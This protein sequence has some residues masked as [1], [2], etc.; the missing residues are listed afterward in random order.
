MTADLKDCLSSRHLSSL[1]PR[2]FKDGKWKTR[3]IIPVALATVCAVLPLSI[4]QLATAILVSVT[5]ALYQEVQSG[6]V[7][8]RFKTD[9]FAKE[10]E[11]SMTPTKSHRHSVP[12]TPSAPLV[13][14]QHRHRHSAPT[15]R[16][17][18]FGYAAA[19]GASQDPPPQESRG[20]HSNAPI[21][22]RTARPAPGLEPPAERPKPPP[23]KVRRGF[24]NEVDTL[25]RCIS[26]AASSDRMVRELARQVQQTIRPNFPEA[27]VVGFSTGDLAHSTTLG[28][29][30]PEVDLV[31]TIN[32]DNLPGQLLG[33]LSRTGGASTAKLDGRKVQKSAIRACTNRLVS[34]CGFKFRRSAFRGP[35]PKVTLLAPAPLSKNRDD[36]PSIPVDLSVNTATPQCADAVLKACRRFGPEAQSL[37]VLVKRWAR[38]RGICHS[39]KGHLSP[40]SWSLLAAFFLQVAPAGDAPGM[41]PLN[42]VR[43]GNS[44]FTMKEASGN[45]SSLEFSKAGGVDYPSSDTIR[46]KSVATLFQEFVLFYYKDFNWRSE[47]VSLRVGKRAAP[48]LSLPL[49]IVVS[50]AGV[51]T[52]VG[53]H[54]E[55]PFELKTNL[56]MSM[57]EE[58]FGRMQEE[59][60]RALEILERATPEPSLAEL[61]EPWVLSNGAGQD[62]EENDFTNGS[63]RSS[64]MESRR[65]SAVSVSSRG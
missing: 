59:L 7:Q 47:A 37:V 56:G 22:E 14:E 55:D 20:R 60:G 3:S 65:D 5:Y 2:L 49:H 10:E 17:I 57:T 6:A 36:P 27:E 18:R 42:G 58:G 38:D 53:P 28:M 12:S 41:L 32:P 11:M 30:T 35:E 8:K 1:M 19:G 61:L 16:F 25:M 46:R 26:P 45:S 62:L 33:R 39:A 52:Q 63:L 48:E 9:T 23:V 29:G 13:S 40:Y 21:Q 50:S 64:E 43:L 44:G 24:E 54:I 4:N 34:D 51:P 15:Q 31:V